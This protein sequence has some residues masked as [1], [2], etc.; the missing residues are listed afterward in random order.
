MR[1]VSI[2]AEYNPFHNGH[3]YQLEEAKRS[4]GAER[5]VVIMSASFVQRGEPACADKF[6]RAKWALDGGADMVLELPDLF[7]LSCAERFACG[8]VRVLAGAGFAERLSFGSETGDAEALRRSAL[9]NEDSAAVA[10]L[11]K[12]GLSY[13][14]AVAGAGG[15]LGPNDIL[16]AEYLRAIERYSPD[17]E[18]YAVMREGAGHTDEE[19]GGEFSSGAAIRRVLLGASATGRLSPA[20][21]DGLSGALPR[22]VLEDAALLMRDGVFPASP[23]GLSDAALYALRRMSREEMRLLPEVAEGLEN[24]FAAHAADSS[25]ISELL[26]RV[27]SRRYTMAR[28]KRIAMYALVGVTERLQRSAAEDDGLLYARV[29]GVRKGAEGLISELCERSRIPVV[30]R[31]SDA[32]KLPEGARQTL[33][34][35]ELAHAVRAVGQ[36][37]DKSFEPDLSHRLIV[38]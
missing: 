16:G 21:L 9:K 20:V 27:K 7:S 19:L 35:S 23:E 14:A 8:A 31:S 34:L 2:I 26:G 32:E 10:E 29:L 37:Y 13:P 38:R 22:G 36:P 4:S 28:L 6:T 30:V 15:A 11:L 17:T 24:L 33:R 25:G 3:A 18:V 5:A 12:R 1:T